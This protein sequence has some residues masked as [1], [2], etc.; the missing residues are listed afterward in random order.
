MVDTITR[1]NKLWATC[2]HCKGQTE[3]MVRFEDYK[4]WEN[5]KVIQDAMPYLTPGEREVLIAGR[6]ARVLIKCLGVSNVKRYPKNIRK[7]HYGSR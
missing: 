7:L 5:G 4:A 1:P 3:M 2:N 6:V